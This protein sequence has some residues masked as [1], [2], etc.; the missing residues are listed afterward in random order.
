MN[1][2]SK[3]IKELRLRD[4]YN[5]SKLADQLGLTATAISYWERGKATPST[6]TLYK[7]CD[8]FNVNIQELTGKNVNDLIRINVYSDILTD[9]SIEELDDVVDI[10]EIPKTWLKDHEF[11]ALQVND[12]SMEPRYHLG[13]NIIFKKQSSVE[14]GKN[15]LVV[16]KGET[17]AIF[18]RVTKSNNHIILHPTN[19][20][21]DPIMAQL[22]ECEILGVP[23]E[24]RAKKNL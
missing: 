14:A 8:I 15:A 17:K 11:F 9:V 24:L 12:N 18:R 2:F 6:E 5:Q 20:N 7:I 21:F 1:H 19:G 22:S 3:K 10:L 4:G 13:D 23:F 16:I